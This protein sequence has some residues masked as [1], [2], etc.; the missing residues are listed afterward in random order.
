MLAMALSC[1]LLSAAVG[2][3]GGFCGESGWRVEW[4]DEFDGRSLDADKWGAVVTPPPPR[5]GRRRHRGTAAAI[6]ASSLPPQQ[7][8]PHQ[9]YSKRPLGGADGADCQGDGCILL[10]ACR[11]AECL[12][13]NAV[14]EAGHLTLRSAR[15]SSSTH[16]NYTTGAVSTWGRASWNAADGAFRVCISAKLPGHGAGGA[17]QGIWPAHW[18][19]PHDQSCDPDEGEMDIMEMVNGNGDY[20]TTYHW[21]TTYPKSNC[22]YPKGHEHQYAHKPLPKWNSTFHEFAV[23][24]SV[25]HVAFVLDGVV[26]INIT[27][28]TTPTPIFWQV[29]WYLIMNTAIGGGWPGPPNGSTVWPAEHVIDY[30][31]VARQIT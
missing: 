28:H 4:G 7:P 12:A 24:R 29:P 15:S 3:G 9:H 21:Q 8:L 2:G 31:R 1:Q 10:G 16:H 5:V 14:V 17:S 30:V 11:D 13:A 19:M 22:S 26:M 6:A 20:E 25:D 27:R 18:M 23:E